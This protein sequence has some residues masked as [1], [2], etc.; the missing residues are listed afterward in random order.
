[1]NPGSPVP[2][3][4]AAEAGFAGDTITAINR[5]RNRGTSQRASDAFGLKI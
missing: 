3:Y 2:N 5:W 1:M 4:L